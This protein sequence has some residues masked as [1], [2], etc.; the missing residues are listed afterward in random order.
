M[1]AVSKL[2]ISDLLASVLRPRNAANNHSRLLC[3]R[4]LADVSEPA[5]TLM[6]ALEDVTP[7]AK[8]RLTEMEEYIETMKELKEARH[9]KQ[10]FR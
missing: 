6:Q 4:A 5:L 8:K 9:L 10:F 7:R 3:N 1:P 2:A